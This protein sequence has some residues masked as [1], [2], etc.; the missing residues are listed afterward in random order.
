[1]HCLN[2]HIFLGR[3]LNQCLSNQNVWHLKEKSVTGARVQ[4]VATLWARGENLSVCG[5]GGHSNDTV[6]SYSGEMLRTVGLLSTRL[7]IPQLS[8]K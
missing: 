4:T 7:L 8:L 1:M 3:S 2:F 5:R 6:S